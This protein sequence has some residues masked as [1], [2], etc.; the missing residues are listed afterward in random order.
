[1]TVSLT[2][3][4]IIGDTSH[5]WDAKLEVP[6]RIEGFLHGS[7]EV[8]A[9]TYILQGSTAWS[10]KIGRFCSIA[11]GV[12]IGPGEH[13]TDFLS[14]HPFVTDMGDSVCGFSHVYPSYRSWL[15]APNTRWRTPSF[16]EIGNDVWIGQNVIVIEGVKV[17][18]GAVLAGGAV[19]SKDVPPYAIVGGVPAKVLRY[20][21]TPDI[22]ERLLLLRWWDYDLTPVTASIDFTDLPSAIALIEARVDDGTLNRLGP[23]QIRIQAGCV[24]PF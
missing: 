11:P 18:D 4:G 17:G 14:T 23:Q 6:C 7:C 5:I 13:S 12:T 1:M 24:V 19:V 9:Y 22:I 20:R 21:F 10:S 3:Y 16:V 2:A 8:G 15:G